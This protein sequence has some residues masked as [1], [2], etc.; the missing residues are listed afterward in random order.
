MLQHARDPWRLPLLSPRS[1]DTVP[2]LRATSA[3]LGPAIDAAD[4]FWPT[5]AKN[6]RLDTGPISILATHSDA[7]AS[8]KLSSD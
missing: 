3:S 2:T 4:R 8:E 1:S 6:R 7:P 5:V